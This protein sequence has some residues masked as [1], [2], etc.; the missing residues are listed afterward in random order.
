MRTERPTRRLIAGTAV[1]AGCAALLSALPGAVAAVPPTAAE[2]ALRVRPAF[3][4]RQASES[5]TQVGA[6]P[7]PAVAPR[8]DLALGVNVSARPGRTRQQVLQDLETQLGRPVAT[9]RAYDDWDS[10]FPEPFDLFLRD[11]GHTQILSFSATTS[12]RTRYRYADLAAAAPGS[13]RYQ[14]MVGW[15]DR[16][17]SRSLRD[18]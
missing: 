7:A 11:T 15:A 6:A 10:P 16:V 13:P 14:E 9:Y 4:S 17:K 18:I 2:P 3:E 1:L 8:P 5:R 12:D